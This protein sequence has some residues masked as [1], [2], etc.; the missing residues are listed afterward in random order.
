MTNQLTLGDTPIKLNEERQKVIDSWIKQDRAGGRFV[1]EVD[2]EYW[3]RD[4]NGN[5]YYSNWDGDS[6]DADRL[7]IGNVYRTQEDAQRA[8][9]KLKARVTIETFIEE[10]GLDTDVDWGDVTQGKYFLVFDYDNNQVTF[11]WYSYY[12]IND[13]P[14][15]KTKEDIKKLYEAH[16]EECKLLLGVGVMKSNKDVEQRIEELCEEYYANWES[17]ENLPGRIMEVVSQEIQT[18][19]EKE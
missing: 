16:P 3:C 8:V 13:L 12:R 7:S 6:V 9:D 4:E 1:P 5:V 11:E 19:V 17:Y 18:A 14:A 15:F 2:E 10:H